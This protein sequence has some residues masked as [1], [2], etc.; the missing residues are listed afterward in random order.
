MGREILITRRGGAF[1]HDR[2]VYKG[3]DLYRQEG[4]PKRNTE[5]LSYD[6][7]AIFDGYISVTP[8]TFDRTDLVALEKLKNR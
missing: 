2:F 6:T 8:M 3:N 5:D 4:E 7:G 1:Y